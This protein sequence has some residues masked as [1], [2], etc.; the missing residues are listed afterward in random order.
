MG[1]RHKSAQR[2]NLLDSLPL[3]GIHLP[4]R[5][6]PSTVGCSPPSMPSIVLCLL[7]SC[8]RWFPPSLLCRLAIFCLVVPLISF[9]SLVAT[10]QRLVHLLSFI[11]DIC[12]AP[13]HFCF[14]DYS[15]ISII[16]VLFLVSRHGI[17]SCSFRFNISLSIALWAVLSLFEWSGELS[18][19][20]YFLLVIF[21]QNSSTLLWSCHRFLLL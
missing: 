21:F 11:L 14:S 13:L 4:P 16:F 1:S 2:R 8:S 15:V 7:L 17:L 6:C 10:V 18:I 3:D 19:L 5:L 12:P 20:E 9:L